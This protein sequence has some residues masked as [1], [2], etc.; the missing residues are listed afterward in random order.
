MIQVNQENTPP[1]FINSYSTQIN[2]MSGVFSAF[3]VAFKH[4]VPEHRI[5]IS[6]GMISIRVKVRKWMIKVVTYILTRTF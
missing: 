3:L 4:L 5:A 1:F 2:G 6:G